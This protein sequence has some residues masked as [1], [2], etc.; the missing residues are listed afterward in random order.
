MGNENK[1]LGKAK[2]NK[3]DEFYT[4]LQDIERELNKHHKQNID[5]CIHP[6]LDRNKQ[7]CI[8]FLN[9]MLHIQQQYRKNTVV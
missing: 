6:K 8:F 7:V 4:Q 3:K 2:K 5:K 9:F 1:G